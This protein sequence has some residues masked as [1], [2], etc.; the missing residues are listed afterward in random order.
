MLYIKFW[1][2]WRSILFYLLCPFAEYKPICLNFKTS[3]KLSFYSIIY[4]YWIWKQRKY[5][6]WNFSKN[7]QKCF[8]KPLWKSDAVAFE[9][10]SSLNLNN[11]KRKNGNEDNGETADFQDENWENTEIAAPNNSLFQLVSFCRSKHRIT[12]SS[13]DF[14]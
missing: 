4:L 10:G 5:N 9:A 1:K 2:R 12:I 6:F 8:I 11:W 7:E 13:R 14:N 3:W